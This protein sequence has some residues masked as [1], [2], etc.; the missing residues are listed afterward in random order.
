MNYRNQN[1]VLMD[2]RYP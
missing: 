1:L 2:C